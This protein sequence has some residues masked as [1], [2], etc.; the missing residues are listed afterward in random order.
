MK[1]VVGEMCNSRQPLAFG[2]ADSWSPLHSKVNKRKDFSTGLFS[3]CLKGLK[4]TGEFVG[5]PF[6]HRDLF[7]QNKCDVRS[8]FQNSLYTYIIRQ[9]FMV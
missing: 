7:S 3:I 1:S 2:G 8:K 4:E 6:R 5:V 9:G